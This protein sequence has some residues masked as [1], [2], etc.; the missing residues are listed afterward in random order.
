MDIFFK[1][2]LF[3]FDTNQE[4]EDARKAEYE[5][6]RQIREAEMQDRMLAEEVGT[7]WEESVERPRCD[8]VH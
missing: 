3:M 7:A 6:Q 4:E 2:V 1:N 8:F 5:R